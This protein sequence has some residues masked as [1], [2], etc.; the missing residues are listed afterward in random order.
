[1]D[2]AMIDL[3]PE[4]ANLQQ[5]AIGGATNA[6][7]VATITTNGNFIGAP[8]GKY[9]VVVRKTELIT[10]NEK[11]EWGEPVTERTLS[12][13][14]DEFSNSGRTP[15]SLEVGSSSVRETLQVKKK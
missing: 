14:A 3:F 9:K 6:S 10:V 4:D 12:L 7:G 1:M 5:W 8:A 2:N 11:D 15:L 13:L